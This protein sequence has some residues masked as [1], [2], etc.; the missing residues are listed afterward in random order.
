MLYSCR[1]DRHGMLGKRNRKLAK[2]AS[3]LES[4]TFVVWLPANWLDQ[5]ELINDPSGVTFHG[6]H[7]TCAC[8]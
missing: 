6:L 4:S 7:Q 1:I 8:Q 3:R 2:G 5:A